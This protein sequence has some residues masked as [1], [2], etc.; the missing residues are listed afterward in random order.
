[1][2]HMGV[3]ATERGKSLLNFIRGPIQQVTWDMLNTEHVRSCTDGL[4]NG[5]GAA[6]R[7]HSPAGREDRKAALFTASW[8]VSKFRKREQ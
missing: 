1:M 8:D 5:R 6:A 3:L 4:Q 2:P 7:V